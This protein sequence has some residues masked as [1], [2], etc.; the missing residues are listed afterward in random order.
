MKN[1]ERVRIARGMKT[2]F[3]ILL[4][5]AS[6]TVAGMASSP[7]ITKIIYAGN[8]FASKGM[9]CSSFSK[10]SSLITSS[11]ERK[12]YAEKEPESILYNAKM[13]KRMI[14]ADP[15]ILKI[16]FCSTLP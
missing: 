9:S 10:S 1:P 15:I 14:V 8:N 16:F 13:P 6:R 11:G 5:F 12:L 2:K 7:D 3:F 4:F